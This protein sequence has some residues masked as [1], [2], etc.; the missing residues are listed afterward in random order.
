MKNSRLFCFMLLLASLVMGACTIN[1]VEAETPVATT[2]SASSN[3]TSAGADGLGDPLYPQGGNGGY[4]A[5]HYTIELAVDMAT[6]EIDGATTIDAMTT[7]ELSAFNLDFHGLEIGRVTVNGAPAAFSRNGD[8]LTITPDAPLPTDTAFAVTVAYS[9]EPEPVNDPG[10]SFAELGWKRY[11]PG[12]FTFSEPSGSKSWYPVNNHPTDKATYTFRITVDKPY[13]VAA[14]GLLQEEIDNGDTVTYVWE[15]S[16]RM[17]SYLAT[18]NIAEFQVQR[19]VGPDGLPIRNYFP[20]DT[21]QRMIDVFEPTGEM[22]A[23]FSELIAPYPFEA[24]GVA[25]MDQRF[26]AALENQTMSVFGRDMAFETVVVHELAHQWFGDSV[27]LARWQDMWLN[28]GF[29]TY[30]S[31]LWEEHQDGREAL[32][33]IMDNSY[34]GMVNQKLPAPAYP[35]A[36]ELFGGAVYVRGAWVLHALRLEVGDEV[37]FDILRTYYDRFK[38]GNASTDDFIAVSEAV[39]GLDLTEFFDAWL[40]GDEIPEKP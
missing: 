32:E 30:F 16:D 27:S 9:G 22:I 12:V 40:F 31:A 28:E 36:D 21:S 3:S 5:I 24:Y 4:D 7:Q 25:V 39:S 33:R 6:N 8:E 19:L 10:L 17:A 2:E 18:V 29:A 38:D 15:A 23:Y 20:P 35:E 26:G 37:F 11:P 1:F 34:Q 13:V 14:N